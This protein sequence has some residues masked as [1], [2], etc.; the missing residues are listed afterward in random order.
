MQPQT[1][2]VFD[3]ETVPD[4]HHHEGD[5][6]PILPFHQVVA[7]A[8]LE[9]E[10]NRTGAGEEYTL[11]DLRCGGEADYDEAKLV[12]GFF[13]YFERTRPRLVTYNGRTFDLPVLKYR[14][15]LHGVAAPWLYKGGERF[16]N[17]S[18]RYSTEWHFDLMDVLSDFG[19]SRAV[20]LD[21]VSKL[22]GFPGKFG[23]EG[24]QHTADLT[25]ETYNRAIS[26]V[27]AFIDGEKAARP[28]L[29]E[30][31]EAWGQASGDRFLIESPP[32]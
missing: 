9:A 3:I 32:V 20:K 28:Y 7:I 2:L 22:L 15:M 6:F 10:I 21:E 1:L 23:I 27:I 12:Q 11:K 17:Y 16:S 18:Y 19:A 14:A 29:G 5:G 25:K 26:E 8:F 24:S 4:K 31:M 30:F 13:Q